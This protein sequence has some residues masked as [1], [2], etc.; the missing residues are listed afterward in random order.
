MRLVLYMCWYPLYLLVFAVFLGVVV[1]PCVCCN[2]W[3]LLLILVFNVIIDIFSYSSFLLAFL[4]FVA[5]PNICCHSLYFQGVSTN[6]NNNQPIS[7]NIDNNLQISTNINEIY[8]NN[9]QQ[10]QYSWKILVPPMWNKKKNGG[11]YQVGGT[12]HSLY[13]MH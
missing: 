13:E 3:Y 2:S 6:I 7:T 4:V 11:V 12:L 9:N 1:I 5:I 8:V 10:T